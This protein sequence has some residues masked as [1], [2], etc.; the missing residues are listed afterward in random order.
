M[1][2][3]ISQLLFMGAS[4]GALF[5]VNTSFAEKHM[6]TMPHGSASHVVDKQCLKAAYKQRCAKTMTS[7][8]DSAGRLWSVWTNGNFLYVNS[9]EDKGKTFSKAIKVNKVAENISARNEHRP[10]IKVSSNGNIYLSW[11]QKLKKRFTGNIRFSRS[12]DNG[13]SFSSPITVNDNKDEISHRFDALGVNSKGDI[14][15]SWLDKRDKVQALK[16]GKDYNGAA[17][18]Y[19]VSTDKGLSFSKNKKIADNS[20]E[21]CRMAMAF[22]N[23]GLPV[24]AWRHIYG[25]N[26]RDHS[27][28]NFKDRF[29]CKTPNRLSYDNWQIDGCPHHGPSLSISKNNT[30]HAVWFNNAEK[31]H[32]VFYANSIDAGQNFSRPISVG[33]YTNRASHADILSVKG[34]VFI[35]WQEFVQSRYR[36]SM[37]KSDNN[38]NDWGK[39]EII[40]STSTKPDYP[41]L[42]ADGANVFISWH[43]KGKK[44]HLI[45]LSGLR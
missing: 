24:I 25:D 41:F 14:Y 30:Y 22:D 28:V 32:G 1:K 6:H 21:C 16:K 11:T 10:K 3:Y 42:L 44:Y 15:I 34:L 8:F 31:R 37:M 39:P 12:I 2:K 35:V 36:L 29:T 7:V 40:S 4:F 18:Y 43:L 9:S 19:A 5:F 33:S 27:I 45:N 26:I 23:R 20:C 38:G 17:A 13:M